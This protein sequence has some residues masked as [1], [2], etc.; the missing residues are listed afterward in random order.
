MKKYKSKMD[1][2]IDDNKGVYVREGLAY[3]LI[4]YID[5]GV[6]E[7]NEFRKNFGFEND[8]SKRNSS[9]NNEDICKI[10]Y[11]KTVHNSWATLPCRF[12]FCCS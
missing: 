4:R 6:I 11:G 9:H 8:K 7:A 10:N 2:W 5:Q 3:K 12:V 1:K